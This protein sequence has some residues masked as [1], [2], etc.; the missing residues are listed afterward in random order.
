M[1][2]GKSGRVRNHFRRRRAEKDTKPA[3]AVILKSRIHYTIDQ[4]HP[5]IRQTK[6]C[7][8]RSV[9]SAITVN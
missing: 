2:R 9:N 3:F 6:K 5:L 8:L 4:T 1:A 7:Q